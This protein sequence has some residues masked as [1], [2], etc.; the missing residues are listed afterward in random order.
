MY[1]ST[2]VIEGAYVDKV[3]ET[4][5][6]RFI[7]YKFYTVGNGGAVGAQKTLDGVLNTPNTQFMMTAVIKDAYSSNIVLTF[8]N[9]EQYFTFTTPDLDDESKFKQ[10]AVSG[11]PYISG[12]I[13]DDTFVEFSVEDWK[14]FLG[15]DE[16]YWKTYLEKNREILEARKNSAE[17]GNGSGDTDGGAEGG[18]PQMTADEPEEGDGSLTEDDWNLLYYAYE[19][20]TSATEIGRASC[21]ER[22]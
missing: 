11:K 1:A 10:R 5:V 19:L 14:E 16:E 6:R 21:R 12:Y 18:E 8:S 2:A 4:V 13:M 9:G 20:L 15:I 17:I 3:G 7:G 22:V